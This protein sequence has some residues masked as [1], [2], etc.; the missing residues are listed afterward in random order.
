MAK[1]LDFFQSYM[2]NKC[3]SYVIFFFVLVKSYSICTRVPSFFFHSDLFDNL[4][5]GKRNI[6]LEKSLK[7]VLNFGF[8]NLYEWC[9]K[10][11]SHNIILFCCFYLSRWSCHLWNSGQKFTAQRRWA[12]FV[13][14]ISITRKWL[15]SS[16]RVQSWKSSMAV[17]KC[18]MPM[19]M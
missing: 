10:Q 11:L 12:F 8:K 19:K 1:R 9:K 17:T 5:Y 6:V 13:F 18:N 16:W 2:Y 15:S 14:W 3:A 4:E 7:K